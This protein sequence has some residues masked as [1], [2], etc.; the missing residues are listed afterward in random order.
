MYFYQ[1]GYYEEEEQAVTSL[2]HSKQFNKEE[3]FGMIKECFL[4]AVRKEIKHYESE[5]MRE[6]RERFVKKY[7][8]DIGMYFDILYDDIIK[9]LC[10]RFGFRKLDYTEEF[11]IYGRYNLINKGANQYCEKDKK[12]DELMK[13]LLSELNK[14]EYYKEK[15]KSFSS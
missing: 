10:N 7:E 13:Y 3:F 9:R 4:E 6:M 2:V 1:V 11:I 12:C 14:D 5:E 15:I 8:L